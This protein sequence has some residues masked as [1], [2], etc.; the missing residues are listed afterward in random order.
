V[1]DPE[2]MEYVANVILQLI[3]ILEKNKTIPVK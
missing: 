3:W 1:I 2:Q